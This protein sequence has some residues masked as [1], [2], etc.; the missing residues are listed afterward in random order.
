MKKN[1]IKSTTIVGMLEAEEVLENVVASNV[2]VLSHNTCRK[3]EE[4]N[5][6]NSYVAS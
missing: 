5:K 1:I 6:T 3:V 4:L 2:G